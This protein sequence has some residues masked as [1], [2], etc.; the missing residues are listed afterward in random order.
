MACARQTLFA[1]AM[2]LFWGGMAG[3]VDLAGGR[4]ARFIDKDGAERDRAVVKFARDSNI[5]DPLPDPT[6]DCNPSSIRLRSDTADTGVITLDASRWETRGAGY[7]YRDRGGAHGGIQKVLL[8]TGSGGGRLQIGARGP[9]YGA[10]PITGPVRWVEV[11]LN[12]GG[13]S[14]CG[15]FEPPAADERQ[16]EAGRVILGGPSVACAAP[17]ATPE[18]TRVPS[19]TATVTP[20]P[21]ATPEE[22]V[23][24]TRTPTPAPTTVAMCVPKGG[25]CTPDDYCC[26]FYTCRTGVCR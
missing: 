19:V 12:I 22:T 7:L 25:S 16:N 9:N 8:K 20:V 6:C 13:A 5:A 14:Y 24:P 1:T 4:M 2:V 21:T 10:T 15:R 23:L 3:A 18:A 26:S 11:E 17:T